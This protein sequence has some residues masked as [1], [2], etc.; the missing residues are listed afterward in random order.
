MS[1]LFLL[2][3]DTPVSSFSCLKDPCEDGSLAARLQP[4]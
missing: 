4:S 3:I 1:D 2:V